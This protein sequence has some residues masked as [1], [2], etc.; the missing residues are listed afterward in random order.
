MFKFIKVWTKSRDPKSPR[1]R[2]DF[3]NELNGEHIKYVT[4]RN[5]DN[6]DVIGRDGALIVKDE[7]DIFLV[8]ASREVLFRCPIPDLAAWY[9]MSGDGVVLTGPDI[10]HDGEVR[11]ITA[12][13]TYHRK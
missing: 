8:Y 5:G 3:A 12:Y 6:E 11:T 9:L 1:Y 10:E 2:R 7:E 13:F 4:E